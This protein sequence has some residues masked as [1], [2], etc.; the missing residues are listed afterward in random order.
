MEKNKDTKAL[1]KELDI[2]LNP[3]KPFK[4]F[5]F[6]NTIYS[7]NDILLIKS[8][9]PSSS[10]PFYSIGKLKKI[11]SQNGIPSY[12]KWPSIEVEWYYKKNELVRDKIN[13]LLDDNYYESISD[14]EVFRTTHRDTIFIETVA[15]KARVVTLD[16][17]VETDS[18][19]KNIFFCRGNY[20]PFSHIISPPINTW[21]KYC[22]CNMPFNPNLMY[23]KCDKCEKWYHIKCVGITEEELKEEKMFFCKKC[24]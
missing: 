18:S 2:Y 23:V 12:P 1:L 10:T 3:S 16:E 11:I 6:N 8:S 17:Y 15:G 4:Q 19:E 24:L 14:D 21:E 7:I 22:F 9:Y 5:K 13:L 20:D